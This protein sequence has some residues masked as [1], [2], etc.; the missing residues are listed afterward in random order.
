MS[1]FN[2][3]VGTPIEAQSV[4]ADAG[5]NQPSMEPKEAK[6]LDARL[7]FLFGIIVTVILAIVIL[8]AIVLGLYDGTYD[9][10]GAVWEATENILLLLFGGVFGGALVMKLIG[11]GKT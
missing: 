9:E 10:I 1:K 8:G 6:I 7:R 11:N 3:E 5:N 4:S 2:V